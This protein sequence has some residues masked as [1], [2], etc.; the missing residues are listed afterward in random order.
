M[1]RQ[2]TK[3][4]DEMQKLFHRTDAEVTQNRI[5]FSLRLCG[6]VRHSQKTISCVLRD[7]FFFAFAMAVTRTTPA[8]R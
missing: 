5:M 1:N 8:L 7:S 2:F 4:N 6:E 3:R